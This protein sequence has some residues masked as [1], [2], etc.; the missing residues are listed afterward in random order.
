MG[1]GAEMN[2]YK[3]AGLISAALVVAVGLAGC[4]NFWVAPASS[5]TTTTTTLSGNYFFVLDEATAQIITYDIV[6]GTLTQ[7]AETALP[8]TPTAMAVAPNGDWLAVGTASGIY[9]YTLSSGTIENPDSP[10][11]VSNSEIPSQLAIDRS[12]K[13]ILEASSTDTVMSTWEMDS[14]TA[15]TKLA[16][17]G[18]SISIPTTNVNQIAFM[19]SN[20]YVFVAMGTSGTYEYPFTSN[21][22]S[23]PLGTVGKHIALV[24]TSAL[25]V[26]VDKSDRLVYI[27]ETAAKNSSGGLRAFAYTASSNTL[28]EISGSPFSSG[29][30]GPYAIQPKLSGDYVYVGNT[31]GSTSAGNITGFSITATSSSYTLAKLSSSV[32]TGYRPKSITEEKNGNFLIAACEGGSPYLDAYIFDTSTAGALDTVITS[33][34]YAA[35]TVSAL[36]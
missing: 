12:S 35:N 2:I 29:G 27:G 31:T 17:V 1:K 11:T 34:S 7:V 8:S 23:S 15:P 28:T 22:A 32:A 4:S 21:S 6:S 3:L 18:N 33:S 19:K 20:D 13:W 26:A 25:S 36:P 9:V 14:A 30:S 5:T 16:V 24:G 10:I